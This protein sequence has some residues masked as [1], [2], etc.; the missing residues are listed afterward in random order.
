MTQEPLSAEEVVALI[1]GQLSSLG[2]GTVSIGGSVRFV[3]PGAGQW[4]VVLDVPHGRWSRDDVSADVTIVIAEQHFAKLF[5]EP[6]SLEAL[7]RSGEVAV[8]G[9]LDKL[10]ALGD[11]LSQRGSPLS[12]RTR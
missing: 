12:V 9:D 7:A 3:V 10:A 2:A 6:E 8:D 4:R 5:T 1:A 11:L